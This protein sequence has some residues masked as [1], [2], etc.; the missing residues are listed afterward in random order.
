[1]TVLPAIPPGTVAVLREA[2]WWTNSNGSMGQAA[3][4]EVVIV[5]NKRMVGSMAEMW[6]MYLCLCPR[7]GAHLFVSPDHLDVQP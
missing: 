1:M 6:P 2:T 4:G 5:Q 7:T 3:A